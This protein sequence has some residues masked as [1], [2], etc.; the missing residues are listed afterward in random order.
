MN[1]K[2]LDDRVLVKPAD[3]AEK[4]QGGIYIPQTAQ[5]KTQEA[6]VV[7]VGDS[8]KIKVKVNDKIL[9]DKYSGTSIKLNDVEH[10]ILK[11]EDILAILN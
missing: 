2:P 1:V 10:I 6:I 9:H 8:D 3:V 5:E 11:S 4:T 7:A